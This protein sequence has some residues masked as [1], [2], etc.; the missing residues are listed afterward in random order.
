MDVPISIRVFP[1]PILPHNR[2][3]SPLGKS[4][5]TFT[6]RKV[7]GDDA[8]AQVAVH[9]SNV[10]V[11]RCCARGGTRSTSALFK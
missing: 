8:D 11:L 10:I 7:S 4:S 2:L 9:D 5:E 6:R 1:D 3:N